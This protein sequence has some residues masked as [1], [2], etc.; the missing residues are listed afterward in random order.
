MTALAW[1]K[2]PRRPRVRPVAQALIA[3]LIALMFAL[4]LAFVAL[5]SLKTAQ[6]ASQSPPTYFPTAISLENY[7]NLQIGGTGVGQYLFN[8]LAVAAGTV[9]FTLFIATL[10]GYAFSRFPFRGSRLVFFLILT[11]IMVPFQVLLTPLFIVVRTLHVDNSLLG[12][13]LVYATFQLPFS[14]FLL[15]IS[16]DSIPD[17]LFDAIEVDGASHLATLRTI[18]PLVSPGLATTA[19]FAFFASWNEFIG[20][21]ILLSDQDK[22]T[23]PVMLTTLII[24]GRGS[25][26]WGLLQAGVMLNI[27]PC[28]VIFLLLQRYYV[29]G[30]TAGVGK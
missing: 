8:S 18:L 19:L 12:L 3:F 11:S 15:K 9:G 22:F 5:S 7:T 26:N 25:V 4:P 2:R 1:N 21:L 13:V 10:A 20:A 6:Q 30:L 14:I 24:G 17:E 28:I 29:R 16:F 27:I 23:L